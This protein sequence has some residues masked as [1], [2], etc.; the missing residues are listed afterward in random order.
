MSEMAKLETMPKEP[1]WRHYN[2]YDDVALGRYRPLSLAGRL[3]HLLHEASSASV[4]FNKSCDPDLDQGVV[5]LGLLR[6][7]SALWQSGRLEELADLLVALEVLAGA[8]PSHT[9]TAKR[10]GGEKPSQ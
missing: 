8:S 9:A 4:D 3:C 5:L 6:A 1:Q 10:K 7:L 2:W